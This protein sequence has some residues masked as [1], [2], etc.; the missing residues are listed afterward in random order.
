MFVQFKTILFLINDQIIITKDFFMKIRIA[1]LVLL[2]FFSNNIFA[3][4]ASSNSSF[5]GRWAGG[6]C[7]TATSVGDY[8]YFGDGGILRILNTV[9]PT[10]PAL[11]GSIA[12]PGVIEGITIVGDT[13]Y[14]ADG[15]SGL[16]IIKLIDRTAP[17][18][19]GNFDTPGY[20]YGVS[21]SGNYAYLADGNSGFRVIDIRNPAV[22]TQAAFLNF[23]K[24]Y[25]IDVEGNYAYVATSDAGIT[26]ININISIQSYNRDYLC[27]RRKSLWN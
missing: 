1:A 24:A 10:N 26:I 6:R 22:P 21:V 17:T 9:D 12:T 2:A 14:V 19:I 7:L 4:Y 15:G 5:I 11:L 16:R 3:Q 27:Y 23:S 18:E 20:T 25:D 13:A 8:T